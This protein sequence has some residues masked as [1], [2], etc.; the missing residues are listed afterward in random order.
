MLTVSKV[1]FDAWSH[2]RKWHWI[3]VYTFKTGIGCSY[4]EKWDEM[5]VHT[6]ESGIGCMVTFKSEFG[7]MMVTL[8]KVGLDVCL[9]FQK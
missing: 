9:H 6:F 1:A 8:S 3:Y 4:F 7:C 5:Y 2:F